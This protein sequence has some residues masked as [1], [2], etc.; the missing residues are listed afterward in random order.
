MKNNDN[1]KI[2]LTLIVLGIIISFF[3]GSLAYWN[4]ETST[5]QRTLVSVQ[6]QG[7]TLTITGENIEHTGMYPTNDCDGEGAL[8]GEVATVTAVNGTAS[9]METIIRIR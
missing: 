6:V 8:I 7:A 1:K 5:A 3:G 2:S 9:D 4:W